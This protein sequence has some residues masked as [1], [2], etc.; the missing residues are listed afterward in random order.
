MIEVL[1]LGHR[2]SRD[3]RITTHVCLVARA[4]GAQQITIISEEVDENILRTVE[5]VV[6]RWGGDFKVNF[7]TNWKKVILAWRKQNPDGKV[8]HLTMYGEHIR[9]AIQKVPKDD[10]L[11]VVGAEK[12]PS[13]IYHI[14]DY[15]IAVGNQPHSEVAALAIFLDRL[16]EGKGIEQKFNGKLEIIPSQRGKKIID[17]RTEKRK[18]RKT[19]TDAEE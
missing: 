15:N 14:A 8:V 12:V 10:L 13:E 6:K 1:R 2:I 19:K 5:S 18:I 3:K 16:L 9:D 11:I 17:R 7:D 4:F